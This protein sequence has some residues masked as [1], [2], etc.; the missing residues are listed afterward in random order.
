MSKLESNLTPGPVTVTSGTLPTTL[1]VIDCPLYNSI[2]TLG[3][4]VNVKEENPCQFPPNRDKL[5]N[6]V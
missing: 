3:D 2:G 1:Q 5:G 6:C 4:K